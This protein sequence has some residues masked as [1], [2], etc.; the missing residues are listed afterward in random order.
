MSHLR[1]AAV[2]AGALGA[3]ACCSLFP[4][5]AQCPCK[6][7]SCASGQ[8]CSAS[9]S[10]LEPSALSLSTPGP[11]PACVVGQTWR[12]KIEAAGGVPPYTFRFSSPP[13]ELAWLSMESATGVMAGTPPVAHNAAVAVSVSDGAGHEANRAYDVTCA[14]CGAAAACA[15]GQ[16]CCG[17]GGAAA[18]FDPASDAAHCGSCGNACSAGVH[19]VARCVSG[20]CTA[21]CAPGW[22]ACGG[23]NPGECSTDLDSSPLHCGE[24]GSPCPNP[25]HGRGQCVHGACKIACD[26]GYSPQGL[27]CVSSP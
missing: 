7:D 14:G 24:C 16:L 13:P 27:V 19:A 21:A 23:G 20:S 15:P 18:C 8:V 4:N 17:A 12:A 10:C 2:I 3:S 26:P 22:G 1:I 25:E 5:S 9:G 6:P 11:L